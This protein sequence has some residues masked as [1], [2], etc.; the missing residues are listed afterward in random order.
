M[1]ITRGKRELAQ[2]GGLQEKLAMALGL[3][4]R[5]V[6]MT[7][8]FDENGMAVPV[9]VL[10]MGP[11]T[12]LQVRE[13]ERD[14]YHAVQLG[15]QDKPRDKAIRAER[16]HVARIDSKRS[17]ART[18]GGVALL[19]KADCEPKRYIRE[20]RLKTAPTQKVGENLTVGLFDQ[21]KAVDVV[22]TTKG[23]GRA[24]VMKRWGFAG[25]G[26]SHGVKKHH[27]AAGSIGAHATDR[28]N[29]GKMK[30]GKRMGGRYGFERVTARNLKVVK[31]DAEANLLL[32]RGAV[33]GPNTGYVMV[34]PTKKTRKVVVQQQQTG[35]GAAKKK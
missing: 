8:I 11:C 20:F 3:L 14:G 19:P 21:V 30:K 13:P 23:R 28:G 17:R 18:S 10:E 5:K 31:V 7:Q 1:R 9:T 27:R 12:V 6:G 35:K 16:G 2:L 29:S 15:Y 24:G 32:V 34:R 22:G 26:A 25:L 4:G 33:P